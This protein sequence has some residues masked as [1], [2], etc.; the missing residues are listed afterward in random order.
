ME[1]VAIIDFFISIAIADQ[2]FV[3]DKSIGRSE[4]II[5]VWIIQKTIINSFILDIN[6]IR[7]SITEISSN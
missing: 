1:N 2:R 4:N 3:V 7:F 6:D 5:G